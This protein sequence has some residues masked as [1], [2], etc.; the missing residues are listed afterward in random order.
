L[1]QYVRRAD[2]VLNLASVV[3]SH[4]RHES[5]LFSEI[6]AAR[7]RVPSLGK[8]MP[9]QSYWNGMAPTVEW[10]RRRR[11]LPVGSVSQPHPA[12]S[13][14]I[15]GGGKRHDRWGESYAPPTKAGQMIV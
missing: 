15:E 6:A 11:R 3:K 2:L 12:P 5:E 7:S 13:F 9:A 14:I 1:N 4:V 10:H 8:N